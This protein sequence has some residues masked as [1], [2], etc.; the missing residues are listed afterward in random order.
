MKVV[1][2][3]LGHSTTAI[4]ETL[5]VKVL[6]TVARAAAERIAGVVPHVRVEGSG[7]TGEEL[8]AAM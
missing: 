5:Y 3:R 1:S 2:D 7:D 4:T 6:P 8:A